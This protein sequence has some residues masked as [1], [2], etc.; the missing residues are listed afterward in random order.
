AEQAR[1][2][3]LAKL[4]DVDLKRVVPGLRKYVAAA[5]CVVAMPG[6]NTVCDVLSY[7]CGAV[8][9]P[10]AG[11][12]REQLL[13]AERLSTWSIAETVLEPSAAQLGISIE[14][15]LASTPVPAPLPLDGFD[16][17]LNVFDGALEVTAATAA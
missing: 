9:V 17:A 8:F 5:D 11:P 4:H 3:R 13:R 2:S 16:R 15:T 1:L 7:Q 12:S 14:R 6:Y 10:R